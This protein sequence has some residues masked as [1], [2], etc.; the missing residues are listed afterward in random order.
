MGYDAVLIGN[1]FPK[2]KELATILMVRSEAL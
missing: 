2:T 1:L